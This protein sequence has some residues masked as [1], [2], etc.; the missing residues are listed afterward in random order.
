LQQLDPAGWL[1]EEVQP[2]LAQVDTLLDSRDASP[3]RYAR[4]RVLRGAHRPADPAHF[5][6]VAF[7]VLRRRLLLLHISQPDG[8]AAPDCQVS[9][10]RLVLYRDDWYLDAL[11][12][13]ER[14]IVRYRLSDLLDASVQ[15]DV[16]SEVDEAELDAALGRGYGMLPEP[17]SAVSQV[18]LLF[19]GDSARRVAGQVWH[20]LQQGEWLA[21]H[22]YR[23]SLPV[24]DERDLLADILR[25]GA[26]VEVLQPLGLR[27]RVQAMLRDAL[28]VYAMS[29]P[30]IG[31]AP[32][33]LGAAINRAAAAIAEADAL[34][35]LAG[36]GMSVDAGLPDYRGPQGL[37]ASY[38]ILARCRL[39]PQLLARPEAF[40]AMPRTAWGFYGHRL[41]RYRAC[42]PHVGHHLLRRW[43][44]RCAQGAFVLTS[45]VDGLFQ[46]AGF[47]D[48]RLV[49][50]NGSL[51]DLQCLD[52]C[53]GKVWREPGWLP[54]VDEAACTLR[55]ALPQCPDCGG[56]ARPNVLMFSDW[57]W[58]GERAA[59]QQGKLEHWLEG[60]GRLVIIEL[61]AGTVVDTLRRYAGQLAGQGERLL[62]RI[63]PSDPL[64]SDAQRV[65][66][67]GSA[68]AMLA[69][70]DAALPAL[71]QAQP[72]S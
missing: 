36:A 34:L 30:G 35:I 16:C 42:Q 29:G 47:A 43:S 66:L 32:V 48:D 53:R 40:R 18:V 23:L 25:H 20:P 31:V 41:R 46:R 19:R 67:P 54:Q 3:Q 9:P 1:A 21:A 27:N 7:A 12:E 38:P 11:Q 4:L 10:Q 8:A 52:N 49:E 50:A 28:A 58:V 68:A 60:A 61:G 65:V 5:G 51:L 69:A 59:A 45:N 56:L 44:E 57:H 55:D 15:Q 37:W 17:A 26:D 63:N 24:L 33:E 39:D 71:S 70:I 2:L 22:S 6:A 72:V 13:Q 14:R 62:I 64:Q